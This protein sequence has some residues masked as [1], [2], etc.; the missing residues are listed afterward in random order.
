LEVEPGF[1]ALVDAGLR[2]RLALP[3]ALARA[4]D[5]FAEPRLLEAEDPPAE[6]F[7]LVVLLGVRLAVCAISLSLP[8]W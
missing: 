5:P 1:L 6:P 4:R 7:L 3:F 8:G 2:V